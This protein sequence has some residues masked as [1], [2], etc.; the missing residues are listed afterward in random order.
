MFS[1]TP[2]S[3]IAL[4]LTSPDAPKV[5]DA[6]FAWADVVL[7][8]FK[9]PDLERYGLHWEHARTVNPRLVYLVHTALGPEGP[10]ADQGGYDG[11]V[12]GRSGL[13][14][15]MNRSGGSAPQPTRPAINDFSTGF[16]S[17]FAVM[18]GLRHRDQ[19]GEGQRLDTSLL[20]T[21][22]SL[23]TPTSIWF[24]SDADVL[25][26]LD[27]ELLAMRLAGLDFDTQRA[28]YESRVEPAK[29]AFQL[30]FRHYRTAD[31][32]ISVAGMSPGLFAKFHEATGI[33]PPTVRDTNDPAF[34]A[35]VD[36]AEARFASRT[37][38]AWIETLQEV[39][40]PCGPTTCRMSRCLMRRSWRTISWLSSSTLRSVRTPRVACR[41]EWK[42][43]DVRSSASPRL[44]EHTMEVMTEIGRPSRGRSACGSWSHRRSGA[45]GGQMSEES[46]GGERLTPEERSVSMRLSQGFAWPTVVLLVGLIATG[47]CV[48]ATAVSGRLPL[49]AGLFINSLVGYGLY[50]VVHEAA[51][52]SISGRN[53][54]FA[55][56]DVICGNIAAQ[57][58]C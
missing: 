52:R 25:A 5:V 57:L 2:A 20:G 3:A 36:A 14:W 9:L 4:D 58:I 44:A 23:A 31:G 28:H 54:T 56:W 12:Q 40:Y 6:L 39:G 8:A 33:D 51:H 22:M 27:E 29:G 21:A 32:L 7:V 15:V 55:R 43:P 1:S 26:E 10:D 34:Q 41:C 35:T 48:T 47:V 30:Y 16:V 18:A 37:T 38:E 42:R 53:P 13:G 50:T 11:L 17:A 24:P 46:A 49:L 19:T 45:R